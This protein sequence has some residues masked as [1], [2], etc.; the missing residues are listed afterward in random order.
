MK[1][2][3]NKTLFT[4]VFF[5]GLMNSNAQRVSEQFK[6]HWFDGHAEISSYALSQSRYGENREGTA[7]LLFVTED[8][9]KKE[10]VKANQKSKETLPV[11][12][13]NRTKKFLTGIYP[14]SIMSSSFSQLRTPQAVIKNSAS[15]QEWCGQ[16]YLQMNVNEEKIN[17]TSHSYF[18]G[19][20]DQNFN[21]EKN[22]TEDELWNLI[23]LKPQALPQGK[24]MLIPSLESS[25]MNHEKIEAY[26]ANSSI[27]I[28]EKHTIYTIAYPLLK[29]Y[30]AI[31]F[32]NDFPRTIEGWVQQTI[33]NGKELTSTAKRIHT[34][35]RQ[36]WNENN[37]ASEKF[38]IPFKL[39]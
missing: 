26:R 31:K 25:R 24:L 39:D 34:E 4:L 21:L 35:R 20:A 38:R 6:A 27:E 1:K 32:L 7:V 22:L 2:Q 15:I 12:K 10:Q 18:E 37:N 28:N 14:Y 9:L 5:W 23:R 19:E 17:I 16:S 30:L 8:F 29:R 11:L 33:K 3:N 36:Y 13:L